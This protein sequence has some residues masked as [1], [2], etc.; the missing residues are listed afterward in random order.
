MNINKAEKKAEQLL[1][2][3]NI[4]EVPI[5]VE[6]IAKNLNIHVQYQPFEGELS[7]LLFRNEDESE[8][9]I[10]VNSSHSVNR[11]RF[12]IAHELGHFLLHKGNEMHV[13]RGFK[14]NFR[15]ENSSKAINPEEVEANAFAAA[16]LMPKQFLIEAVQE[17]LDGEID[18]L[19][20]ESKQFTE[21]AEQFK[22]SQQALFIRLGKIG[23]I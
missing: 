17:K 2:K 23:V 13:D 20:N 18:L 7:G 1:N 10:G 4:H 6:E 15:D 21:I 14:L 3:L 11:Q 9:I 19:N 22:V 16:L 8:V 5:P 12:T